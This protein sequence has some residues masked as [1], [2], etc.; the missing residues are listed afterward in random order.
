MIFFYIYYSESDLL[1][2]SLYITSININNIYTQQLHFP[3]L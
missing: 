2:I 1:I 3:P